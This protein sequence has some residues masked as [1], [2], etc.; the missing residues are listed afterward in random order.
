LDADTPRVMSRPANLRVSKVPIARAIEALQAQAGVPLIFS[1][2]ELGDAR[3]SCDCASATVGDALHQLLEGSPFSYTEY[4]GSI[5]IEPKPVKIGDSLV[6]A[7]VITG[8]VM[9]S[10][11][12]ELVST[13]QV[14]VVGTTVIATIKNTGTF[15][16]SVPNRAVTLSVRSIGYK[17][18]DVQVPAGQNTVE[19]ALAKD[20]FQLEAVVVTGQAT[21]VERKNLANAVATV[22]AEQLVKTATP[23]VDAALQGKVAG[24][25]F[26]SNSGAPGGG[27]MQMTIRGVSS[28]LGTVQPLWV[29]D[30]VIINDQ[31]IGSGLNYVTKGGGTAC[32]SSGTSC[33]NQDQVVNRVADLNPNDIEN[34]EVLK[35]ASASAIY[36]SKAN[37]GVIL[38]TTKRGKEGDAQFHI[39]Q[40][41]GE[42]SI[43]KRLG[44]FRVFNSAAEAASVYGPQALTDWTPKS[45]DHEME[46]FG[47][48]PLSYETAATATGGTPT[49]HYFASALVNRDGGINT[50][51]YADKQSL[52]LNLNQ[53]AGSRVTLAWSMNGIHTDRAPGFNNN[54]NNE[55]GMYYALFRT[56]TFLDIGK[57]PDGTYPINPYGN[58]NPAQTVD[59]AQATENVWR[60][61]SSGR[62]D[63]VAV[64]SATHTLRLSGSGGGDVYSK[65][66]LVF[67]PATL[68]Y[69]PLVRPAT[70]GL[71]AHSASFVAQGNALASLVDTYTP[72]N[73]LFTATTSLGTSYEQRSFNFSQ[74]VG[75]GLTTGVASVDATQTQQVFQT[76]NKVQD[77]GYF[78]QEEFLTFREK[79][80]LTAGFRADQS[81]TNTDASQL[82]Y[83]PKTSASYRFT[84]NTDWLDEAKLRLAYGQSGNEPKYGDKFTQLG[85]SIYSGVPG[86]STPT[87]IVAPL[88]PER[89][90]EIE[91]GVDA[92]MLRGRANVELTVYQRT[93]SDLLL[94][95]TLI[96]SAGYTTGRSNGAT[97]RTRGTEAS[98]TFVP[99][100][101]RDAEWRST[102]TFSRDRTVITYLPVPPFIFTGSYL[103]GAARFVRDSSPTDVWGNDTLP[104]C[105][106]NKYANC[107]VIQ[108]KIG[109][110]NPDFT[111]GFMNDLRMKAFTFSMLWSWQKGGMN[112]DLTNTDAD[113]SQVSRDYMDPCV[114]SCLGTET[115][116]A[117]RYR[118]GTAYVTSIYAQS[119]T[120]VKLREAT[121]TYAVPPWLG[122]RLWRNGRDIKVVV[123]GKNLLQFTKYWGVDPEVNNNG[124]Q[125]IKIGFDDIAP[126][127]PARTFWLTFELGF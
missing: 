87:A 39:T 118:L 1:P 105:A 85:T 93:I 19:I 22:E 125:A 104:G 72:G 20:F 31:E 88:H 117:Q 76:R 106:A 25:E 103:R 71:I 46:L 8:R 30:G 62:L 23:T 67:S 114:E 66:D 7:R 100:R 56:P 98:L 61:I 3:V 94:N 55:V 15:T 41:L 5:L 37:N 122:N 2:T 27:G 96:P 110:A 59:L 83:Y 111:M 112:S 65:Q 113:A 16:V 28:V 68:Q 50:N 24:A 51:T 57:R 99:M 45:Y 38:I 49:T 33:G 73:G 14:A 119:A 109:N 78:L 80:L 91:S 120:Y 29:V 102:T 101:T 74:I 10:V 75:Q 40:R 53:T 64:S 97:F 11:T 115:L 127:P 92:T 47:N 4:D 123:S 121:L 35:G 95:R 42:S 124:T 69:E 21:A 54:D 84:P 107:Q 44:P 77:A 13:G 12:A 34:I 32:N 58:S 116:G 36:G 90:A 89:Q 81:S 86:I 43:L 108:K 6:Q 82:Y 17:R 60:T 18:K 79:L 52:R 126:Y 9:D 63:I 48:K 26:R 70:P